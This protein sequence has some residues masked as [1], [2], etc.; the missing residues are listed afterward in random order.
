MNYLLIKKRFSKGKSHDSY[1]PTI[2]THDKGEEISRI[3]LCFLLLRMY[4]RPILTCPYGVLLVEW[5]YMFIE[6][7]KAK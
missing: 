1:Y 6:H 4:F 5:S 7:I 2:P 3:L